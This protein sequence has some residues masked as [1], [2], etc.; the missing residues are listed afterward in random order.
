[1]PIEHTAEG[2]VL[3]TTKWY[4]YIVWQED[5]LEYTFRRSTFASHE[6]EAAEKMLATVHVVPPAVVTSISVSKAEHTFM[7]PVKPANRWV[8][9]PFDEADRELISSI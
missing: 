8:L 2:P 1:M 3:V 9:Q 5:G 4:G 6:R 7:Y